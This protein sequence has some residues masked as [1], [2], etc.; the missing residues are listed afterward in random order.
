MANEIIEEFK[1]AFELKDQRIDV[2][3]SSHI[4]YSRSRIKK[5]IENGSVKV[6]GETVLKTSTKLQVGQ[7]VEIRLDFATEP[8][9]EPIQIDLDILEILQLLDNPFQIMQQVINMYCYNLNKY[10]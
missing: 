3:L 8:V 5:E 2:F 9:L 7:I 10:A 6:D 1:V 4:D